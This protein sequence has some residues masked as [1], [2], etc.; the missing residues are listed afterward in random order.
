MGKRPVN[1]VLTHWDNNTFSYAAPDIGDFAQGSATFDTD[2]SGK[3]VRLTTDLFIESSY[4]AKAVF[5]RIGEARPH[6]TMFLQ[7]GKPECGCSPGIPFEKEHGCSDQGFMTLMSRP[8]SRHPLL[9]I[10]AIRNRRLPGRTG[11]R[12]EPAGLGKDRPLY[13]LDPR[14]LP[15]D[16]GL[17]SPHAP[18]RPG[19]PG[20]LFFPLPSGFTSVFVLEKKIQKI[21]TPVWLKKIVPK[22]PRTISPGQKIDPHAGKKVENED[23]HA[24]FF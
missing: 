23:R 22:P 16:S 6:P 3:P 2:A 21:N 9:H 1:L 10:P 5:D 20:S 14:D 17:S 7:R 19:V 13:L 8:V 18:C 11:P 15:R 12:Q 24:A 4:G